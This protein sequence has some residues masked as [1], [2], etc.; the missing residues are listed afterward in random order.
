MRKRG[1]KIVQT[2]AGWHKADQVRKIKIVMTVIALALCIS[3]VTGAV[4]AWV[5]IKHPFDKHSVSSAPSSSAAPASSNSEVLPVYDDSFNLV[6]VNA[7]SQL[8]SGFSVQLGQFGGVTV[9]DRI[10]PALKKMMEDAKTDGCALKLSGGYVDAK[11]Q[12]KL[13]D[14]GV[15]NLIKNNG[16]SQVRAQNKIQTTIGRGGYNENQTG[17]AVTFSAEGLANNADFTATNQYKWLI[18]NSVR[19]GFVLRYAESKMAITG[20]AFNPRHFRYVGED[21]AVKM[22]E[23]SMCLEEYAAYVRQQNPK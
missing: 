14:A 22:R 23:Y 6:V 1:E 21:N 12:D 11:E 8:K 19:Y 10:I 3:L 18:K 16:Y 2:R 7:T 20:M 17:M 4:L 9:D 13:F 15:Q 5:Q